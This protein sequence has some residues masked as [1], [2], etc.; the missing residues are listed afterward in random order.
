MRLSLK[1]SFG[2]SPENKRGI[3][4]VAIATIG[5]IALTAAF[6]T[7]EQLATKALDDAI[8]PPPAIE[9]PTETPTPTE[10]PTF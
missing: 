1:D 4:D 6:I 9:E 5:A 10:Q 8:A 7:G 2:I 3:C